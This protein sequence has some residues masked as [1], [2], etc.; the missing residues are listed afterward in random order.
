VF[1]CSALCWLNCE[2]AGFFSKLQVVKEGEG[3]VFFCVKELLSSGTDD[4][5]LKTKIDRLS[6]IEAIFT[7]L[8][9]KQKGVKKAA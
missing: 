1:V 2:A 5:Q 8:G 9:Y 4:V 3:T 6:D 7:R